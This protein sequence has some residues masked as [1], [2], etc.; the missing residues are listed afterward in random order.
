MPWVIIGFI[1]LVAVVSA[2]VQMLKS[3]QQVDAPRRERP[4]RAGG[5]GGGVKNS[6]SDIDR[7]LQELDKLRK[8]AADGGGKPGPVKAKPAALAAK[9]K[10]VV[11]TVGPAKRPKLELP[12]AAPARSRRI[13]ELP[14]AAVVPPLA[15]PPP[16]TAALPSLPAS[17]TARAARPTPATPFGKNLVAILGSP[18]AVPLAVVLQE[19]LGPPKC[20]RG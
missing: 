7:F 14:V 11:P 1:I 2:V 19:V 9:S 10:K 8:K 3:Q 20:K 17:P 4:A 18:Q 15:A 16:V 5:P 12:P 13:D 6:P